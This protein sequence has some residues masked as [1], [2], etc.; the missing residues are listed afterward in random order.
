MSGNLIGGKRAA[1]SNKERHGEDYYVKM[2]R[3]GGLVSSPTKGFGG[4]TPEK[5]AAAGKKGGAIGKR[6]VNPTSKRQKNL[7]YK[8]AVNN[9][10][11]RF[12]KE[13]DLLTK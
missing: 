11:D 1:I 13:N 7:Q 8:T 10:K 6:S 9:F 2:G 5:R 3:A 12:N 4:M